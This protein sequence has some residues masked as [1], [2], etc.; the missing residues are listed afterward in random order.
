MV[1]VM[2][3]GLALAVKNAFPENFAEYV[4]ACRKGGVNIG[5][6]HV[7]TQNTKPRVIFNFPTKRHWKESSR[8][9]YIYT[10]LS[11]LAKQVRLLGVKSLAVPM[12]GCGNGGLS[13]DEVCPAILSTLSCLDSTRI[14]VYGP[15]RNHY[16][17]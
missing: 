1:G 9:T 17:Y 6:M 4:K 13:W 14:L 10:G 16:F 11:D 2:G 5:K 8:L 15:M 3:K 12:L 7:F